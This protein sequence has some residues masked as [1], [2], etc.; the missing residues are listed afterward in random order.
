[1]SDEIYLNKLFIG[2]TIPLY[3]PASQLYLCVACRL[4]S[5]RYSRRVLFCSHMKQV[6]YKCT[7]RKNN[8]EMNQETCALQLFASVV[9]G[10]QPGARL[11]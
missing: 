10:L 1:M 3:T 2:S 11:H 7:L 8:R 5:Q 9:Y 4:S 6:M